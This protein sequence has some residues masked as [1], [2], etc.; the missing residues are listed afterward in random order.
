[1]LHG[2][3]TQRT[4]DAIIIPRLSA[5]VEAWRA[6]PADAR[7]AVEQWFVGGGVC[8]MRHAE[9]RPGT[10]AVASIAAER[11]P[12]LNRVAE[13]TTVIRAGARPGASLAQCEAESE[14][15]GQHHGMRM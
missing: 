10:I 11:R 1:M 2:A 3:E 6:A 5:G 13:L 9:G 12:K 14:C 8:A 7:A 15:Q 4:T